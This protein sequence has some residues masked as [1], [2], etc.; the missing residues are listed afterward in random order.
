M[1]AR[2]P[3]ASQVADDAQSQATTYGI[4]P[5]KKERIAQLKKKMQKVKEMSKQAKKFLEKS[6]QKKEEA[7]VA[8]ILQL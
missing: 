8:E 1:Q 6:S 2:Q 3:A 4:S 5:E 7:D